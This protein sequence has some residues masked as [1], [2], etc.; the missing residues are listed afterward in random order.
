MV[1]QKGVARLLCA[2]IIAGSLVGCTLPEEEESNTVDISSVTNGT[3]TI[4][5]DSPEGVVLDSN[6]NIYVADT[7]NH[8]IIKLTSAGAFVQSF[9]SEGSSD[10]QFNKPMGIDIDSSGNVVVADS[11]NDRIVRFDPDAFA[12]SFE[13]LGKVEGD[14]PEPG[15]ELG[16][17]NL[18][19]DV[20]V[21]ADN[22]IYVADLNNTRIQVIPSS[23][24]ASGAS[25]WTSTGKGF[26]AIW[27]IE[28]AGDNIYATDKTEDESLVYKFSTVGA[29]VSTW[30]GE[31]ST[32]TTLRVP[33]GLAYDSDSGNL[34]LCDSENDRLQITTTGGEF[35]STFGSTGA[36]V[37]Q[38]DAP[39]AID[40]DDTFIVVADT[41]NDR[42]QIITK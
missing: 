6:G 10:E 13:T 20:A 19:V 40:I 12:S 27:G 5:F 21:G 16:E 22:T 29:V 23:L 7:G 1:S 3:T 30:G 34:Y 24:D 41:D 42:I 17:F 8:R 32:A 37:D 39:T 9:G 28:V 26:A 11:E 33:K 35:V 36:S 14:S 25:E 38:F 31:G 15:S 18:P 2:L 4:T